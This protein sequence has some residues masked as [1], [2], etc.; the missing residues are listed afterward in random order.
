MNWL[1]QLLYGGLLMT[2][3]ACAATTE[4]RPDPIRVA[5]IKERASWLGVEAGV[6]M[7]PLCVQLGLC[8]DWPEA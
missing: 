6:L 7:A 2:D 3:P 8:E 4:T 1:T 5:C